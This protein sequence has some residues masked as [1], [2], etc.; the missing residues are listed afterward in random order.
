MRSKTSSFETPTETVTDSV[1]VVLVYN[2]RSAGTCF[3]FV[4]D[5]H[6]VDSLGAHAVNNFLISEAHEA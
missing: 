5:G 2:T 6:S 1:N 3:I 4:V